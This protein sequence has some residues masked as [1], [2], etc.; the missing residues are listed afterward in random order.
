MPRF[1]PDYRPKPT[2]LM[3]AAAADELCEV[4][5][6]LISGISIDEKDSRG[7]TALSYACRSGNYEVAQQ[8]LDSGADPNVH[9]SYAMADTPLSIA[10]GYGHFDLV[11]LLIAHGA[12]P[13]VY[14]GGSGVRA[15]C[16]ARWKD[17]NQISEFLRQQ[18]DN[19]LRH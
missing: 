16:Y 14:A 4:F 19:W 10:A 7:W 6:L 5:D 18:E 8:L 12:D 13:T 1:Q 17:Y 11:R 3:Q 15:E 9:E 2:P